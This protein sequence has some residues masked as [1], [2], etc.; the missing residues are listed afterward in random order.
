M[1]TPATVSEKVTSPMTATGSRRETLSREK[2]I[3]KK[4]FL[5]KIVKK[6]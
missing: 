4:E 5:S 2:V 1:L 3:R 6:L